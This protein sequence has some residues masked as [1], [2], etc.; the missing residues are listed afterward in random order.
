[1]GWGVNRALSQTL[2][3][4]V[5]SGGAEGAAGPLH[6]SASHLRRCPEFM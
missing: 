4:E 6:T 2:Y 3:N 5:E 1:V